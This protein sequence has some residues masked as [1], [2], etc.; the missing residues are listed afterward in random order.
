MQG[1]SIIE[2]KE[3]QETRREADAFHLDEE[4]RQSSPAVEKD[5]SPTKDWPVDGLDLLA[6]LQSNLTQV[7]D[8]RRRVHFMLHEVKEGL[9]LRR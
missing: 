4:C 5:L 3:K 9:R 1:N 7:E 8:L 6:Q 2:H